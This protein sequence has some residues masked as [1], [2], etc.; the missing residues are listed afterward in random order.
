M[1]TWTEEFVNVGKLLPRDAPN[2]VARYIQDV[3]IPDVT[4]NVVAGSG[5][6]RRRILYFPRRS[7]DHD[8]ILH[9]VSWPL[10]L[11]EAV[12]V[13]IGPGARVVP[14]G[15]G[16]ILEIQGTLVVP[17]GPIF[18]TAARPIRGPLP[19]GLAMGSLP[20]IVRLLGER[21]ERV[22]PE[23]WGAGDVGAT[24][25][26][27]TQALQEA[28]RAS[29]DRFDSRGRP[30]RPLIVELLG[31]YKL[32]RPLRVGRTVRSEAS[33]AVT[34]PSE[35]TQRSPVRTTIIVDPDGLA[36]VL[37]ES[38]TAPIAVGEV[39]TLEVRGRLGAEE[40]PTFECVDDFAG[41]AMIH[42]GGDIESVLFHGLRFD[43]RNKAPTCVAFDLA[44]Q[45]DVT[46]LPHVLRHCTLKGGSE[47]LLRTVET[48]AI[49]VPFGSE[50]TGVS[51]PQ[52]QV[53]GCVFRPMGGPDRPVQAAV[54]MIGRTPATVE[55]RGCTF[56]GEA[57]A[58]V[59]ASGHD[60][61]MTNC[62][63]E[64]RLVPAKVR[65]G[66]NPEGIH[67][68]EPEGGVDVFLDTAPE[69]RQFSRNTP[70]VARADGGRSLVDFRVYPPSVR[71]SVSGVLERGAQLSSLTAYDCR[72]TSVQF[73]VTA[74]AS[75]VGGGRDST[76]IGL[77][78]DFDPRAMGLPADLGSVPKPPAVHWRV[79]AEPGPGISLLLCGCR[80][81]GVV[82]GGHPRVMA[83][84]TG[85]RPSVLDYGIF[86]GDQQVVVSG[87]PDGSITP[88]VVSRTMLGFVPRRSP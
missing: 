84:Q 16:A 85:S 40:V 45:Q 73:L 5:Q 69:Q 57:K 33:G 7:S 39:G 28:F 37:D 44:V 51:V 79:G 9:G 47:S 66:S 49:A 22:H 55:F 54:R 12:E 36:R 2:G 34:G 15:S 50:L 21:I 53:E 6:L 42:I 11:P 1:G 88:G 67:V 60:V 26:V 29:R 68:N 52:L 46:K 62:R 65:A 80:F 78:H 13:R 23:W 25:E 63:F 83:V 8:W 70:V 20:G 43:G 58:M 31:R 10:T 27:D 14:I 71:A 3:V 81:D 56:A 32:K 59:Y 35:T 48:G 74:L 41:E 18:A 86:A 76:I 19:S 38:G 82:A 4:R 64:N 72:S 30:L 87:T 24:P 75:G 17:N 61:S 77:H